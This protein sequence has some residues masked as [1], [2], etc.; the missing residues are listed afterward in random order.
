MERNN[1]TLKKVVAYNNHCYSM[2]LAAAELGLP[3]PLGDELEFNF[4]EPMHRASVIKKGNK[5]IVS[6]KKDYQPSDREA[7][8]IDFSKEPWNT[9]K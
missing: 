9:L 2:L 6:L 4:D 1:E 7:E 8:K 5:Y 3:K